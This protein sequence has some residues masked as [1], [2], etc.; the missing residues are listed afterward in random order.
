MRIMEFYKKCDYDLAEPEDN[1]LYLDGVGRL[2]YIT[3]LQNHD[4]SYKISV[5]VADEIAYVFVVPRHYNEWLQANYVLK[6][7]LEEDTI[8]EKFL[9]EQGFVKEVGV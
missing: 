9:I 2:A 5:G 8:R 6:R 1:P 4:T 7:V 3:F